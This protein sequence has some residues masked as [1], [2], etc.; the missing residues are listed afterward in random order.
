MNVMDLFVRKEIEENEDIN[1]S[2][3]MSSDTNEEEIDHVDWRIKM[4]PLEPSD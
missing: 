4:H 3:E 2:A 1:L